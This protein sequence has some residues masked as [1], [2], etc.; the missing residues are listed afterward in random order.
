MSLSGVSSRF[1]EIFSSQPRA[2]AAATAP[3]QARRRSTARVP[4]LGTVLPLLRGWLAKVGAS[5]LL[6]S[7]PRRLHVAETVSLGEKRFVSIVEVDGHSFLIGGGSASVSLLTQLGREPATQGVAA[8][9]FQSALDE[10]R[11]AEETA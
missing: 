10:A 11:R 3:A 9:S 1:E 6:Q 4:A 5:R 2:A 7:R 8:R